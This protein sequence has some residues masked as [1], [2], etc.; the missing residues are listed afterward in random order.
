MARRW[1]TCNDLA[2]DNNVVI[3]VVDRPLAT[4]VKHKLVCELTGWD[5]YIRD[6]PNR[7]REV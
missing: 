3:P 2:V 6:L 4:A 1:L 7:Y 5:N